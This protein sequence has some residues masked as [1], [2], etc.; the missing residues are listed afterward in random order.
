M[1][2]TNSLMIGRWF[3][4]MATLIQSIVRELPTLTF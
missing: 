2:L 1:Y 3:Q 4:I